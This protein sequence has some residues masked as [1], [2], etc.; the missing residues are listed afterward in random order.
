MADD[1]VTQ[2]VAA[3]LAADAAGYTRLMAADERATIDALDAARAVFIE[4]TQANQGRIVDTAGD[5]VL[6]VFEIAA[7]AVQA[8]VA[9]QQ[10]LGEINA[11][12][13]EAR[14]MHFRI[15]IHL[16]D[17]HEK[18]DGSVYGDGVNVAAR[19]EG[20]A[21]PSTIVVSDMIQGAVRGR[22]DQGFADLGE[23]EVKN[24]AEPV[25]AYRVL[26]EG[27][28][29][30]AA[31]KPARARQLALA[32]A[33][34]AVVAVIAVALWPTAEPAPESEVASAE[35][36]DPILALPA[37]PSI[38]VLPFDNLSG[39]P[40]QEYFS[41]GITEEII[42]ELTRFPELFV[43]A[44]NTTFQF[45][46]QAVDV[47][48]V[49]RE[50]GARYVVE[51][52]VRTDQETIR[53]TAQM[54]DAE[55]GGH[56]WAETYE[57]D[58]SAQS[59]FTVQDDITQRIVGALAGKHG[60]IARVGE[61]RE[62]TTRTE[63]LAAHDCFLR[64]LV[65]HHIHS[66]E[67]HG[68]ARDCL[69]RS[70]DLDPNYVDALA[71]L[72]Y[73]YVEEY[74]HN[75]N[76]RPNS[77]ERGL[78]LAQRALDLDRAHPAAHWALALAY[79]SQQKLELFYATAERAIALNP[80]DSAIVGFAAHFTAPTGKWERGLALMAKAMALNPAHPSWYHFAFA[81]DHYRK[82][83]YEQA[84]ARI[85]QVT[86][87]TFDLFQM[88]AAAVYGQLGR[89]E[90]AR[91]ALAALYDLHP[92]FTIETARHE[93]GVK[94][95]FEPAFLEAMLDGLRKAGLPDAP[96]EAPSRPVI[97]V[98]PFDSMSEDAAHQF[99]ADGVAE[100]IITRLAR[101]PHIGVIARNSSF[102][103][104]G[105]NV[106]VRTVA[107]EL[108]ATYVLEG[109]V[110]R[111]EDD[112][113]VIAQLLDATD[114]THLWAETYD[115]DLSAGSVFEIQ[116]DITERVVGAIASADS[117]IA[118]AVT[119]ASAGKAPA[120]LASY[121][122]VMRAMDYWRVITPDAHLA[123][124]TCVERVISE[125]PDYA[126]AYVVFAGLTSPLT[127]SALDASGLI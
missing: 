114:G 14:Q 34:V 26:A 36:A 125:E 61:Q 77:V 13:P 24:V 64:A 33:A 105:E 58:L 16:G 106:D 12:V 29:A 23:H 81:Y 32:G 90:E 47:R 40:E 22:L 65:Y 70:V 51:G 57:R 25:R 82:G 93:Y 85:Q 38:A 100:D 4:Q 43:L 44:R 98:L 121:E 79:F 84:L 30:P 9:I 11:P 15:G 41:D 74:R 92:G 110:R 6:A 113:R 21:E 10:R 117:I 54:I 18:P 111:S 102:Q 53:V 99:F 50:L 120:D 118:M 3:I 69:E 104:Q 5:S 88:N 89:T 35:P 56:V 97:A 28:V 127:K 83:E 122:C 75:Y 2:R 96:P 60:L 45:K 76:V 94:R 78:Q 63:N 17:I 95:N 7:G 42:A 19:L 119:E 46:G 71:E 115:R 67:Q 20:L 116:D 108:G 68:M 37:G 48:A 126:Q 73:V 59:I 31:A 27:E 123:A 103:Y 66:E 80:N 52:S 101:F 8:A 107:A 55:S 109:S 72:A 49:G 91:A 86:G 124:R 62:H 112:I 39:D 87:R 1:G